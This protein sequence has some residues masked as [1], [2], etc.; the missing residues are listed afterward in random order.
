MI[1]HGAR[2]RRLRLERG[3][4]LNELARLTNYSKGYLSKVE[5][6]EKQ[7]TPGV[8]RGCD[9]ALQT[10]G[11]LAGLVEREAGVCPYRGLSP[12]E[13]ED[14]RWFFGREHTAGVLVARLA[15]RMAAQPG[16]RGPLTVVA[17]S[18]AGKSSLLRAGLLAALRRGALPGAQGWA[19]VLFVPGVSP[20]DELLGRIGGSTGLDAPALAG[21]LRQGPAEFAAHV[22]SAL[23]NA[24]GPSQASL[25]EGRA[26]GP[27]QARRLVL[28][29]DQLEQV[30]TLCADPAERHT[31]LAA[32]HALA[33]SGAALVVLGLRAD[34]YSHCLAYPELVGSLRDGHLPLGP[35]TLPELRE[36]ISGPARAAGL[37]MEPGLAELLLRD[38]GVP[39]GT[40]DYGTGP[41]HEPGALPLLSHT[42]LATWTRR[43]GNTLTVDGYRASGGVSGA[44]AAT[45]EHVYRGLDPHGQEIAR[46]VLLQMVCVGE[47][48]VEARRPVDLRSLPEPH[49]PAAATAEVVESF[50]RARL[51]T[52]D[53]DHA[54]LAHEALLRAWPRL[55]E[56]ILADRAGLRTRRQLR[57]A[58]EAWRREHR[59]PS[60][61][62][63]GTRLQSAQDWAASGDT[64]LTGLEQEFLDAGLAARAAEEAGARRRSRRLRRMVAL[65]TVLL[66]LAV[67]TTVIAVINQRAATEQRN[68]VIARQAADEAAALRA[69]EPARAAQ[70]SLAAFRLAPTVETRSGLLAAFAAP[71]AIKVRAGD[72]VNR[73]LFSGDGR[74]LVSAGDD[75]VRLFAMADRRRPRLLAAF[76]GDGPDV[77]SAALSAGSGRLATA[78]LDGSV[79]LW[80]VTEPRAPRLLTAFDGH[81]GPIWDIVFDPGGE[82]V[83]T[84]ADDGTARLW[85]V[86]DPRKPRRLATLTGHARVVHGL[87]LSPDGRTLVTTSYDDTVRVWDV[88]DPASPRHLATLTGHGEDVGTAAFSPDGRTL[89]TGSDDRTARLW[90]VTDPRRPRELATIIGHT[91]PVIAVAF[92]PDGRRLATGGWDHSVRISDVGHPARAATVLT[93]HSGT[94]A[95]LAFSSDGST[96]ASASWDHT[97][98]LWDSTGP[99]MTGHGGAVRAVA[100]RPGGRILATAGDGREVRL[101]DVA[102]PYRP[103]AL[104]TL[105]SPAG[106]T[107]ALA[108]SHDGAIL[109]GGGE[110]ETIRLWDV[111]DPRTPRPLPTLSGHTARVRTVAFSPG[112]RILAGGGFGN[113][114]RLWDLTDPRRPEPLTTI[115]TTPSAVYAVA[116]SPDG[117]MLAAG[118]FDRAVRLWR[119]TDPRRPV[120]AATLSGHTN[121]V[122]TVAFSPD[123]RG[124]ASGSFDQSV[125]L[126][127]ITG[128]APRTVA[129]LAGHRGGATA[130]A[131]S[132]DGGLLATT[133][134]DGTTRLWRLTGS[135]G[136]PLLARLTGHAD[137]ARAAAFSP[138]GR[139]VA[140][141][142]ADHKVRLW[143]PDPARVAARVCA[144]T[145]P[146][147]L[148]DSWHDHFPGIDHRPPCPDTTAP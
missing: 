49:F 113:A 121:E 10:G 101:W 15:A 73:A 124:L 23:E 115:N 70:L 91:G 32:V 131:F 97:I 43:K 5:T 52:L 8:A 58:A 69:A 90:D 38:M 71:Y 133:G 137:A 81:D 89:A 83:A 146:G 74:L 11:E 14:A 60:L 50:A 13:P 39:P 105:D 9:R 1:D 36:I 119:L 95:A 123:G 46:R 28:V 118:G 20:V 78:G 94:V 80:D 63:R 140:T 120:P 62:Y 116:F 127:D 107:Y 130:V 45:A 12:Y 132:P 111:S 37:T 147:L 112:R 108:F 102:D 82:F 142:G 93:G 6:G 86:R 21:L 42:L 136:P 145:G 41:V 126:W 61:L 72:G 100:F 29:V 55:R 2:L 125:R 98:N 99:V 51:L 67:A 135:G 66:V 96:M 148:R 18:G 7:L 22:R 19:I 25:A 104:S 143:D 122:Y 35:L 30:F 53:A 76:G 54:Q 56:W 77:E 75:G 27:A 48:N 31:F 138:D 134:E 44:V 65:L 34:F 128:P 103:S 129:R 64:A 84:G 88:R 68:T 109:A 57:E 114:V 47:D 139:T 106:T 92:S 33:T 110:D 24:P 4:S 16:E 79:R 141:A 87:A 144:L 26:E 3:L 85:D 40:A 17:P 59:D 117:G